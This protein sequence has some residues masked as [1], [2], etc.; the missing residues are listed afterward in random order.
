[1]ASRIS[2]I[3]FYKESGKGIFFIKNPTKTRNVTVLNRCPR[4][5]LVQDTPSHYA[6]SFCDVSLNLLQ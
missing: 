3:F 6:L 2:E 1:M 5:S 4:R